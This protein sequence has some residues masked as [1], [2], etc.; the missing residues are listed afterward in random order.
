MQLCS[1]AE[2][3]SDDIR[4]KLD[5][6]HIHEEDQ[7]E[8]LSILKKET[9]IDDARYARFYVRDKYKFNKWGRN[10]ITWQLKAKNI[11]QTLIDD[12]LSQIKEDD[13]YLILLEL[14]Q[15]KQKSLKANSEY[16]LRAKLFRYA[17]SKG[18]EGDVIHTLIDKIIQP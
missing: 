9:F 17:S 3:C 18:F 5:A 11:E 7:T 16:E 15:K 1:K 14:L 2:K 12:A 8:I 6:W 13:Y 4:R 10:K